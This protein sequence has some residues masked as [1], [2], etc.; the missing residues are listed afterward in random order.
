MV[1]ISG[2]SPS[3]RIFSITASSSSLA[4]LFLNR[5]DLMF[6]Y[7]V[8]D[9]GN[10]PFEAYLSDCICQAAAYFLRSPP[11]QLTILHLPWNFSG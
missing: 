3:Y 1:N 4:S 10:F 8:Q 5:N 6:K 7:V 9:L 11:T 2:M